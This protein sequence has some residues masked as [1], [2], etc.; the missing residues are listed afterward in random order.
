M[1]GALG[2]GAMLGRPAFAQFVQ[3]ANLPIGF[4]D[5]LAPHFNFLA[6]PRGLLGERP[7]LCFK[8]QLVA[9]GFEH[10]RYI[11]LACRHLAPAQIGQRGRLGRDGRLLLVQN[12]LGAERLG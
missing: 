2:G 10:L 7:L 6:Q 12:L 8:H 11:H 3:D 1:L 9:L 5:G 4:H